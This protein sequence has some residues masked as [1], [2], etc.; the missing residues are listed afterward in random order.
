M[1]GKVVNT[2]IK[3]G[4]VFYVDAA[5]PKSYTNG[6]STWDDLTPNKFISTLVN[7]PS[8]DNGNGGNIIFNQPSLQ[9]GTGTGPTIT[10]SPFTI[11][12]WLKTSTISSNSTCLSIGNTGATRQLIHFRFL[13]STTSF[14]FS[15]FN[16]DL[17]VTLSDTSTNFTN[18]VG[19]L[20]SDFTQTLYQNSISKS[21][22]TAGGYFVGTSV[23]KIGSYPPPSEYFNGN[24]AS[25]K[26][27]NRA[28]SADE[29]LQNY[30]ATKGRFGL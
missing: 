2:I 5:N 1:S 23:L 18:I 27:Y 20:T 19:S 14:R 15:L 17:D 4:L 26:I 24:I 29:I 10:N 30:N 8:F 25:V 6:S 9:Y 11:S 12:I 28:L 7:S 16:E 3:D 22:R 21:A 13:N